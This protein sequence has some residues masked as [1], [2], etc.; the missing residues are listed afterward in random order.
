M[1]VNGRSDRV[2]TGKYFSAAAFTPKTQRQNERQI[3]KR[4]ESA[5]WKKDRI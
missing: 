1:L 5:A 3:I 4:R 2:L